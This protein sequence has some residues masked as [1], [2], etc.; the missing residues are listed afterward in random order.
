[1]TGKNRKAYKHEAE[2]LQRRVNELED[3][4][5]LLNQVSFPSIPVKS[6]VN[7]VPKVTAKKTSG[8]IS[9]EN[10]NPKNL[11]KVL[12]IEEPTH[13]PEPIISEKI[14][15]PKPTTDEEKYICPSCGIYFN[16]LNEGCCP[17]CGAELE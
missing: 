8:P 1:M 10:N 9:Q 17:V 14:E 4:I 16:E 2:Y 12:T 13:N 7:I 5:K 15:Q 3:K 11:K 6:K